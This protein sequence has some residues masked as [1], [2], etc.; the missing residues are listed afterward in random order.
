MMKLS[1][2]VANITT[3]YTDYSLNKYNLSAHLLFSPTELCTF[4]FTPF[5]V[6]PNIMSWTKL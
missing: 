5:A 3:G 4:R 2:N 6:F 1:Q